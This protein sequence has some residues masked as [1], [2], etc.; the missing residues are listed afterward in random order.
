MRNTCR[1]ILLLLPAFLLAACH[2]KGRQAALPEG[3]LLSTRYAKGFTLRQSEGYTTVT[4]MNPWKEGDMYAR[5]YLVKDSSTKVPPDGAKVQIPLQSMAANSATH[6]G[7]LQLLGELGK[8]TGVCNPRYVY[9]PRILQGVKEGRV[10]GLGDSFQLDIEQLLLL[11]PQAI[12]TSAYNAEDEN[13]K[14]L[15]QTGITLLYNIEWQEEDILGRAE[16]IKF[17][18]AFFDKSS[19]AD[20]IFTEIERNY[21]RIKE[22]ASLANGRPSVMSGEDY[23]GTWSIPAGRSFM[24]QLFRDAGASYLYAG[25]TEKGSIPSD[26]ENMLLRFKE[27]DVWVGVQANTLEELGKKNAQYRLFKAFRAGN[28]YNCNRRTMPDG[29]NDYWES[30]VARPDILLADL[31]KVFHPELL[32]GHELFYIQRL[33]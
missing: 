19:M 31:I 1:F 7:F 17:V 4:V 10:K 30:G 22:Q 29:G 8:V 18:G 15:R 24:A 32:P 16:W 2:Q 12:M 27:A 13:T 23:R 33:K 14:K 6:L 3:K 9:N 20:S 21:N 11:R 26:I 25:N 28:V 5:Y